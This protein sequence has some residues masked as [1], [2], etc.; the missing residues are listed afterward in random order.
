VDAIRC[1]MVLALGAACGQGEKPATPIKAAPLSRHIRIEVEIDGQEL[2]PIDAAKLE[3]TAADFADSGR[4]AWRLR[5]FLGEGYD[6]PDAVVEIEG[7]DGVKTV[8]EHPARKVDGR[9]PVLTSNLRGEILLALVRADD[10]FPA[11][12]GRGGNRGRAGDPQR[13]RDVRKVRL[14]HGRAPG[15][16]I[17]VTIDGAPATWTRDDLARVKALVMAS[18]GGDGERDAWSLRELASTLAAPGARVVELTGDGGRTLAIEP[19]AWAD[20]DRIPV[21][22]TNRRGLYKF[23]WVGRDLNPIEGPELR[24]VNAVRIAK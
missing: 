23:Q 5:S 10:P 13:V 19:E 11:F 12:H 7:V 6:R 22:R 9:E 18:E 4:R 17:A 14:S 16:G 3:A 8:F 21:L 20:D 2:P 15:S 1:A 24:G